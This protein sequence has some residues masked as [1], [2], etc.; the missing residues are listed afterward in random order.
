M[1]PSRRRVCIEQARQVLGVSERR[2]CSVI[3][4]HRSTQRKPLRDD[5]WE[6]LLTADIVELG[7]QYGR[8]G[9]RRIHGL[10]QQAGWGIGLSVVER[11]WRREGLKVPKKQ[12]RRRRLWLNDGSCIR[13]RPERPG[14][15]WSYDFVEDITHN[16][17]KYRMLNIIDE[18]TRECLAMVPQ[19]R[20]RSDDVL[21]VLADLFIER[22]PPEHIRSDNGP[23]F[24][25]KAVRQWLEKVGVRTLF[26][27][28][29]SPWENGYIESFNA[30]LRDELL[31]GEIFYSLKE[32]QII[33]ETWRRHYNTKRPH[34]SLGYRPPA[35]EVVRGPASPASS[36]ARPAIQ[37]MAP[38]VPLN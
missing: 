20:F 28:P 19:R 35:P 12:P 17:R 16:G 15:V 30:R 32:A 3:G 26:I 13:L 27:E 4:Q 5:A 33:I 2:A 37:T 11:I 25:A 34:S 1:S 29:G 18:F 14:H 21:A 6:P 36:G 38:V 9:Y 10:L 24:A 8:Y 7:K 23:E 22:G 31:N